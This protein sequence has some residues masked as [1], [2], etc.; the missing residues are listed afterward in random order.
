MRHRA[1]TSPWVHLCFHVQQVVGWL[2]FVF[3][4]D[5][6]YLNQVVDIN[7]NSPTRFSPSVTRITDSVGINVVDL[8][9][10][11]AKLVPLL[12]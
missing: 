10:Q 3:G 12:P 6:V 7:T 9:R 4:F 1:M 5:R 11:K 8:S 2:M